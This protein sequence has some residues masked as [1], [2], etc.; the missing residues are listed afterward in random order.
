M[1]KSSGTLIVIAMLL[2]A[3]A[4]IKLEP[5]AAK[6]LVSYE[7]APKGCHYLGQVI[8]NQGNFFTGP[9]TSNKNMEEGAM[10]SIRNQ[11]STIGANY[12]QLMIN[13]AGNTGNSISGL[14]GWQQTNVI[15]LGNAYLCPNASINLGPH[16]TVTSKIKQIMKK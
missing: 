5:P 4:S 8:G 15:N 2:N 16:L 14:S 10:N 6:M 12:I 1:H 13:R 3:C 11:A 9:W 7:P